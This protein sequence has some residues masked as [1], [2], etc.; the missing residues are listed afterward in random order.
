MGGV[1]AAAAAGA[2]WGCGGGVGWGWTWGDWCGDTEF[3]DTCGLFVH[4]L[5]SLIYFWFVTYLLSFA[6]VGVDWGDII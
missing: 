3:C 2:A 5:L 1:A 6:V 4:L